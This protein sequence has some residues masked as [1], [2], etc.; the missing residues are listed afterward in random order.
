MDKLY[1]YMIDG[2]RLTVFGIDFGTIPIVLRKNEKKILIYIKGHKSWAGIGTSKYYSPEYAVV[3]K[4]DGELEWPF[5]FREEYNRKTK[6]EVY[7]KALR[8]FKEE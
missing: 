8:I 3:I 5:K 1:G 7:A 4:K 6:K 2:D